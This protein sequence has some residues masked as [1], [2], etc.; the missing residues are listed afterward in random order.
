MSRHEFWIGQIKIASVIQENDKTTVHLVQH[1]TIPGIDPAFT[2]NGEDDETLQ[3]AEDAL[4]DLLECELDIL[5]HKPVIDES[6]LDLTALETNN[7]S[8]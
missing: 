7:A 3:Q 6:E 8:T 2:F 5:D 4:Y 1:E